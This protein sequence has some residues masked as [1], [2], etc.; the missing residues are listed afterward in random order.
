MS[1]P[2]IVKCF[3]AEGTILPYRI[4]KPGAGDFGVV[5]AAAAAD[6]IIGVTMPLV[7]VVSGDSVEVAQEGI[8]EVKLGGTVTRGDFLVSDASGQAITAAPAA[9]TNNVLLGRAQISGVS[10]DIIPVLLTLGSFQG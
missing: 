4:V 2:Q 9:G 7:S 6:K 3:T 8:A 10:G 1:N 5:Q